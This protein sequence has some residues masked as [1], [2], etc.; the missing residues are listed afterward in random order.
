MKEIQLTRRYFLRSIFT[1]GEV[2]KITRRYS[3]R[4]P[5]HD[6]LLRDVKY[7]FNEILDNNY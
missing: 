7:V 4:H 1:N 5:F 3:T 6:N 2:E